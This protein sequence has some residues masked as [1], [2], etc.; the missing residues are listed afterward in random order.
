DICGRARLRKL[1]SVHRRD[2]RSLNDGEL[3]VPER[4]PRGQ[5]RLR[6]RRRG[7]AVPHLA[8]DRP[9]VPALRAASRHP[10]GRDRSKRKEAQ[11]TTDALPT[12]V[13]VQPSG[14]GGRRRA[15]KVRWGSP[16]VYL[17]AIV[18]ITVCITPVLYII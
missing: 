10:G 13:L 4:T 6:Q 3:H 7:D 9:R 16:G 15:P 17:V 8:G 14:R 18:L 2:R 11:M 5:L 1:W 12:S